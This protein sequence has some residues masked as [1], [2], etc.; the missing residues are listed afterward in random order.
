MML[1]W[2]IFLRIK[3]K[4]PNKIEKVEMEHRTGHIHS[5]VRALSDWFP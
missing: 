4:K 2:P 1:Q 3:N 5:Y